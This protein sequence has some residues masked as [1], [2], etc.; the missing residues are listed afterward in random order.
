VLTA[1]A[2]YTLK[3]LARIILCLWFRLQIE[4]RQ[5]VP[6][7]GGFIL[8]CNHLS[9]MDPAVLGASCPRHLVFVA[10][11]DLFAI[12]WLG[13]LL[14]LLRTI[15]IDQAK[16]DVNLRDAVRLLRHGQAVAIFPEG[17]RQFSGHLGVARPGV[18]LLA[19]HANVPIVPVLL[20]GTFQALPPG[21]RMLRPTK[22]RVAFG[23]QIQYPEGRFSDD[24]YEALAHH[25]TASWRQLT[26]GG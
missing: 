22:I 7:R 12:P 1:L 20:E 24:A 26:S 4:G 16:P 2:Y 21:K 8:A 19:T 3:C 5:H 14:R 18:G 25:V 17:G 9:Y 23:P 15:P 6:R 11:A 13:A 10:R